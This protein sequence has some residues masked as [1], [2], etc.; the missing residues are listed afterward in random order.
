M[1]KIL[2]LVLAIVLTFNGCASKENFM[3]TPVN[4]EDF[5]KDMDTLKQEYSDIEKFDEGVTFSFDAENVDQLKEMWGE[6]E[7]KRRWLAFGFGVSVTIGLSFVFGPEYLVTYLLQPIPN[8]TYIWKKGKYTI[9]AD[10]INNITVMY[11]NRIYQW[12]WK[13]RENSL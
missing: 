9:T 1:S 7:V 6:P 5:L 8:E 10:G 11:E 2:L 4:K 3:H 12:E 13:K